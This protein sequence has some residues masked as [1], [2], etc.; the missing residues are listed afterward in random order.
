MRSASQRYNSYPS[1]GNGHTN[2]SIV[3]VGIVYFFCTSQKIPILP[4]VSWMTRC[5]FASV[6]P[7]AVR[8]AG[9]KA[10]KRKRK[11]RRK[12]GSP[13]SLSSDAVYQQAAPS[14]LSPRRPFQTRLPFAV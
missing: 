10:R 5:F 3:L 14:A 11:G 2:K 9:K 1:G 12:K 13:D 4:P 6:S 7:M 8:R